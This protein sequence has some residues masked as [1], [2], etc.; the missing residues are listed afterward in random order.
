V[1][2]LGDDQKDCFTFYGRMVTR[3]L[4]LNIPVQESYWP[5]G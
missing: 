1:A 2:E 4:C 5:V 3:L